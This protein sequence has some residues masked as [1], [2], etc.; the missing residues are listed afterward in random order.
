MFKRYGEVYLDYLTIRI[1]IGVE[2]KDPST[3][4]VVQHGVEL[5][6]FKGSFARGLKCWG[7]FWPLQIPKWR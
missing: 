6:F 1:E 7:L 5:D 3:S 2:T 4:E